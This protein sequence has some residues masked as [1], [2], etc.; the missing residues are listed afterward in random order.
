M[1]QL[2]YSLIAL[3]FLLS[4]CTNEE[5]LSIDDTN[6][7]MLESFQIKRNADGSYALT[8]EV[9]ENVNVDYATNGDQNEIYLYSSLTPKKSTAESIYKVEQNRLNLVFT[10]ENNSHLPAINIYDD[11][12]DIKAGDLG[13]L[14]TY[15]L[16]YNS[17]GTVRLDFKVENGVDVSFGYNYDENIHD[18][19]LSEGNSTQTD[20]TKDYEAN[21]DGSLRIDFVQTVAKTTETKKPRV[22]VY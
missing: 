17:D 18:V 3:T 21:A 10:D 13:L 12:T 20:Y 22:F 15:S 7:K 2:L 14:N 5:P 8:H 9:G 6:N 16:N 1:K 19:Y 4:S 11:D